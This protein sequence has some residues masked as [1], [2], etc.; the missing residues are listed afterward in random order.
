MPEQPGSRWPKTTIGC[1]QDRAR[2]TPEQLQALMAQC[3]SAS[4]RFADG[5]AFLEVDRAEVV[6]Y[7]CRS[8]ERSLSLKSIALQGETIPSGSNE[9]SPEQRANVS[10]VMAEAD[11]PEYWIDVS[12]DGNRKMHYDGPALGVTLVHYIAGEQGPPAAP[13]LEVL[14][15]IRAFRRAVDE[16]LPGM[17]RWFADE[18]LHVTLRALIA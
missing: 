3:S 12:K 5:E 7:Q 11:A 18:T 6:V 8:L 10:R 14:D 2:L 9:P 1:L 13:A 16:T 17:Y 15:A 4:E